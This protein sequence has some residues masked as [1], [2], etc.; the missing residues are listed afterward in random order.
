[1]A[2]KECT[3]KVTEGPVLGKSGKKIC[4]SCPTTKQARDL[5]IVN[6]G[7]D[8]CK[9]IIEAHKACLRSE[10]FTIKPRERQQRQ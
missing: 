5:C 7:E 3:A 6:N 1:M 2:E 4:C 10:G 8:K 9:D